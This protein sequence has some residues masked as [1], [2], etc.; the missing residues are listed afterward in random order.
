[1][2]TLLLC[3]LCLSGSTD[4]L[5]WRL[6][7]GEYAD[8]TEISALGS[9]Y[10]S[11][12]QADK[13]LF[14]PAEL[15][16][17][18]IAGHTYLIAPLA[19]RLV[20][21]GDVHGASIYWNN[22]V[23]LPASRYDLLAELAW[24]CRYDM[25]EIMA[26]KPEVP[27]DMQTSVHSEHCAAACAAGWMVIRTDGLFHPEAI[28]T[29]GDIKTLSSYFSLNLYDMDVIPMSRLRSLFNSAEGQPR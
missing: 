20:S 23:D 2:T 7:A 27:A 1:M 17:G 26:S 12:L 14:T 16:A 24:F 13:A 8:Q 21:R 3:V 25:Y 5:L 18:L 11:V 28:V 4:D 6:R 10:L 9:A 22:P 19:A 29:R 15:R